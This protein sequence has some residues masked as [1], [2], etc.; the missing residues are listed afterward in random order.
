MEKIE[1]RYAEFRAETEGRRLIGT[2]VKY[3]DTAKLPGGIL[4]RFEPG[5]FGDVSKVD[6]LLNSHHDRARPLCRTGGAGLVL[7]DGPD[8]LRMEATLPET[9]DADDTLTLVRAQV[10]RGLSVEFKALGERMDAMTRVIERAA[11]RGL[12]VVDKP[13]YE[14]SSVEARRR[15]PRKTWVKGG[16][17]FG[18]ESFCECLDGSCNKVNFRPVALEHLAAPDAPDVLAMIGRASE[19]VGSTKGGTLK[20][21]LL[22]DRLAWELSDAARDTAAGGTLTDLAESRISIYGRPIIDEA[23]S[24]FTEAGDVRTFEYA[25]VRALLLK[26]ILSDQS[27]EGWDPI[28]IGDPPRRRYLW[29]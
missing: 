14:A 3:G 18:V 27:R 17:K 13:A 23:A 12:G 22:E 7:D 29:L 5:S 2:I 4:E 11:L 15:G 8:A 24:R 25:S 28:I 9:R 10:L 26:P 1:T 16:I 6:I 19:A 20:F 21:S